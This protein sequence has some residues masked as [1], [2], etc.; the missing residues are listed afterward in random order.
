M[1]NSAP[2]FTSP[3]SQQIGSGVLLGKSLIGLYVFESAC[4]Q[5]FQ[6]LGGSC[7]V[8]VSLFS[9]KC[10][11]EGIVVACLASLKAS[12]RSQTV[13]QPLPQSQI[14]LDYLSI[15]AWLY[16]SQSSAKTGGYSVCVMSQQ[17]CE[18]VSAVVKHCSLLPCTPSPPRAR[19]PSVHYAVLCISWKLYVP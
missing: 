10:R 7:L 15:T 18:S 1:G 11:F 12:C 14:G 2:L 19:Y 6:C 4:V 17:L 8:L 13:C 9:S 5:S 16:Y 3:T